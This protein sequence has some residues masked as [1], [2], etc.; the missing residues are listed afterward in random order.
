MKRREFIKTVA[1]AAIA[2]PFLS[3]AEI[4]EAASTKK[5]NLLFLTVD[6]MN[7]SMPG[8]MG[9]KLSLTPNLDRL[10]MK[11]HR[12]VHTRA[13]VPICQPSREAMMTGR[14]PQHSG[15]LGFNPINEGVPTL[16]TTLKEVG[17]YTAAVHKIDHMQP[18][19]CFPWDFKVDGKE[20]SPIEYEA[21][22]KK[23]IFEA[24]ERKQ[25]FF[26]N[27]NINDPHRPFYGSMEAATMDHHETNEYSVHREISD[28][29][30]TV[31]PILDNLPEVRREYAQ[32]CNS[33]QRMDISIGKV[34][35]VLSAQPEAN[36][37]IVLFS[38]DHGMP[39]PFAK[40]TVYDYG[41]RT[42]TLLCYPNMG[43]PQTFRERTCNIDYMPTLLD[44]LGVGK[45]SGLDGHSWVPLFDGKNYD[46]TRFLVTQVNGVSSGEQFP[47][48]AIQDGRY[49]LVF[50]P[51][52]NGKLHFRVEP[53]S[54]LTYS[55]MHKA[56]Q[57]DTHLAVRVKQYILGVPM[58]FYD[59]KTDARQ[60]NNLI[61]SPQHQER[62]AEMK[63][64]L[65]SYMVNTDDP[66]LENMNR[67]QAGKPMIVE[68][69]THLA[70]WRTKVP[71]TNSSTLDL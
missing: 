16:V 12:F 3:S 43:K 70:E 42:P 66:Q 13:A 65:H 31:P 54:G 61:E 29:E 36:N 11:S 26:I 18:P 2:L 6:D 68:Q 69:P 24:R 51:W 22:V 17:Y 59:L 63:E 21:S 23:A 33:V 5:Q 55:A 48:R 52:S 67:F 57:T 39:F 50:M 8:F 20:R 7:W 56:A 34:L 53:M 60:E 71:K 1:A 27:C 58:A 40:A 62:I 64:A 14:L 49:M 15:G 25:P 44:L 45:P 28:E 4:L 37:T 46:G 19:S 9:N 30:V 35:A 41:T 47:M 38:A 10:A 32:Y